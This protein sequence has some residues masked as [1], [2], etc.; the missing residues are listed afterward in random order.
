VLHADESLLSL[1]GGT[2]DFKAVCSQWVA[3]RHS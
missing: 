1:G 2:S 3:K